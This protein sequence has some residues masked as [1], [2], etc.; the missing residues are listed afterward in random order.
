MEKERE[1]QLE[2]EGLPSKG[3]SLYD[4]SQQKVAEVLKIDVSYTNKLIFIL[5]KWRK[6]CKSNE[7]ANWIAPNLSRCVM[8]A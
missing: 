2:L 6:K 1:A 3:I 4:Q 5:K 8:G 7:N